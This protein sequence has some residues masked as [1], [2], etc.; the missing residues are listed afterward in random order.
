MSDYFNRKELI[1]TIYTER[2]FSKAAQKLFISQP[3]LSTMVHK[4]EE[5]LGFPLFDRTSKPISMTEPG[6][7]YIKATEDILHI[8]KGFENYADAYKNLQ[9]GSLTVGSN[10]LFSSLVLPK[11]VSEFVSRYPKIS[12]HLVDD[13][14]V[15]LENQILTGQLDLVIDSPVL[16][17]DIFDQKLLITENLLLAVP[18]DFACN[19]NL[20]AYRMSYD[21]ILAG[22]HLADDVSAVPLKSFTKIPFI[23]MT[24]NNDTRIR[25]DK[26]LRQFRLKFSTILEID[27]LVTSFRFVEMGT[28]AS[29]VTDTLV[30]HTPHR[31]DS[32]YFYR[33]NSPLAKREIYIS[34][35]KNKYYSKAMESF[36][37]LLTEMLEKEAHV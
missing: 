16:S 8:E 30:K 34:Y 36:T 37:A 11:Y 21:D 18:T 15:V 2:S 22:K 13:N 35:K 31:C 4:I 27:R 3:S 25:F 29:V 32:V 17:P 10:Q 28:A 14:S 9:T 5:E 20:T 19:K 1:Y 24:K 12:L 6:M 7:E 33:I 26:I 23:S